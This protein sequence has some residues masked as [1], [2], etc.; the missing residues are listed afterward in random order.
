MII[1]TKEERDYLLDS[2]LISTTLQELQPTKIIYNAKVIYCDD[3][4]QLYNF[5]TYK[6]RNNLDLNDKN[7]NIVNIDTD[8]LKKIDTTETKI[9]EI[10]YKNVIRSKLCK[11]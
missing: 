7:N 2:S 10:E 4:I 3:Y 5:E 11:W 1:Q 9:N 8:N 6:S